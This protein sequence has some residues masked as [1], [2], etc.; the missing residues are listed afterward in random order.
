MK[1]I[2]DIYRDVSCG[3]NVDNF[4]A[5]HYKVF[6]VWLEGF[7]ET[8]IRARAYMFKQDWRTFRL[9]AN[10]LLEIY[11]P[12]TMDYG[13]RVLFRKY[14][15]NEDEFVRLYTSMFLLTAV[16]HLSAVIGMDRGEGIDGWLDFDPYYRVL[17]LGLAKSARVDSLARNL[18]SAACHAAIKDPSNSF[19]TSL[20]AGGYPEQTLH[21]RLH[22]FKCWL[23][24]A[25]GSGMGFGLLEKG[26]G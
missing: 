8:G 20:G 9:G 26:W 24:A 5:E 16:E 18:V 15:T 17:G 11:V 6:D 23:D 25:R 2:F 22:K 14:A 12:G 19:A 1:S 10:L 3:R 7:S 4:L 21:M 13:P